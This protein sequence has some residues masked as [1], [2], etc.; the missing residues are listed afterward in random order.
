MF[1]LSFVILSRCKWVAALNNTKNISIMK[2]QLNYVSLKNIVGNSLATQTTV[3]LFNSIRT[4][5]KDSKGSFILVAVKPHL[6]GVLAEKQ[7]L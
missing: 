2:N 1:Y 4:I 5:N 3:N 7:Y 6:F